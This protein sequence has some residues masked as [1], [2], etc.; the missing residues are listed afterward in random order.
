MPDDSLGSEPR[1]YR[2][3]AAQTTYHV[4]AGKKPARREP[5]PEPKLPQLRDLIRKVCALEA[6][7]AGVEF[8]W[9]EPQS[10]RAEQLR[11]EG[12]IVERMTPGAELACLGPACNLVREAVWKAYDDVALLDADGNRVLLGE[13]SA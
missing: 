4:P 5:L 9:R 2:S 11:A 7:E 10:N 13:D 1:Q 6:L 8:A 12:K 3:T